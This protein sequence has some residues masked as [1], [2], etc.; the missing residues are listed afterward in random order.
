ML[1]MV[2]RRY[3]R[4]SCW[5]RATVSGVMQLE[6][7][8]VCSSSATGVRPGLNGACHWNTCVRLKIWSPKACWI[9]V[10]VSAAPFPRLAQKLTH[11]SSSFLW[12]NVKMATGHL[13]DSKQ[14]R[15]NTAY[16]HPATC[17][18][19]H[20][21]NRNGS[22]NIYRCFALLKLLCRWQHSPEYFGFKILQYWLIDWLICGW[23]RGLA[24]PMH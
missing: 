12:S 15:V 20:W 10:R 24:V 14:T 8:P 5:I 2:R 11:N 7:L 16:I 23:V 3:W 6:A 13:H 17:N 9:T 22:P 4:T 18:L 19:A 1:W 21:F